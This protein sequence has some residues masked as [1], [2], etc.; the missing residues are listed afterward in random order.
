MF[1]DN[2]V[3]LRKLKNLSQEALAEQL[4]IVCTAGSGIVQLGESYGL[5]ATEAGDM[6]KALR[7]SLTTSSPSAL[8]HLYQFTLAQLSELEV[9]LRQ[10]DLSEKDAA[11]LEAYSA[12]L[13]AAQAA[14]STDSYNG[15]VTSFLRQDL[16]SF[17][18]GVAR[19]CGVDLPEKFA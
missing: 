16:G 15:L 2:L 18:T 17:G 9:S 3:T 4:G 13:K 14:I 19:L 12:E 7:F 8:A 6:C 10:K 1:K 5:E 11:L